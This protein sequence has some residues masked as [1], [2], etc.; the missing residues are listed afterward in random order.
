MERSGPA[1]PKVGDVAT[2]YWWSD[3]N[4]HHIIRV[5]D[6]LKHFDTIRISRCAKR[7]EYEATFETD[8]NGVKYITIIDTEE[9][10]PEYRIA[11]DRQI[12]PDYA[13][14]YGDEFWLY[15][16]K[17][18]EERDIERWSLGSDGRY[19]SATL[20]PKTFRYNSSIKNTVITPGV[21]S[22]YFDLEF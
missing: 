22:Y 19:H 9:T 13:D 21:Y 10:D 15:I 6:N 16:K 11:V 17:N 7:D 20:N 14:E 8:S 5:S 1:E 18:I 12:Y 2:S 3:R 4:V